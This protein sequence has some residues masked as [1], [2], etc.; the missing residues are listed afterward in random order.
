LVALGGLGFYFVST[1]D[2]SPERIEEKAQ[3]NF[4]IYYTLTGV[5][6]NDSH[7]FAPIGYKI[8]QTC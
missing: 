2:N 5:V 8:V 1:K 7:I 4:I 6:S 3:K